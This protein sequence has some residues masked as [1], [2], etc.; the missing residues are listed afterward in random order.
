MVSD[1]FRPRS[2]REIVSSSSACSAGSGRNSLAP[3]RMAFKINPLSGLRLAG[4]TTVPGIRLR[5]FLNQLDCL[6]RVLVE[7]DDRHMGD[8]LA[9]ACCGIS[10]SCSRLPKARASRS[11]AT[12]VAA[13]F[14]DSSLGSTRT[15][16]I[17]SFI[18]FNRYENPGRSNWLKR[19]LG[20]RY[21]AAESG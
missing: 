14:R 19:E 8:D 6:A 3:E 7:D 17:R 11:P 20:K 1:S 16:R 2:S 12:A 18:V 21:F 4:R 15:T 10:E 13:Q 9:G 5:E